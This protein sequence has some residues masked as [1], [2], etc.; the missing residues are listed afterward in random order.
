MQLGWRYFNLL[1][2]AP[3][4]YTAPLTLA[5]LGLLGFT[6]LVNRHRIDELHEAL[7]HSTSEFFMEEF[8]SEWK[9]DFDTA[10]EIWIIGVSLHRTINFNSEKIRKETSP[11]SQI[12]GYG[13]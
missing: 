7:T 10:N 11:R 2:I 1:G 13:C 9:D 12:Q 6:S 4:S 3:S 8:P 5:V